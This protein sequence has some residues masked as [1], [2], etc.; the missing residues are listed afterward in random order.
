MAVGTKKCY[1]SNTPQS[2]CYFISTLDVAMDHLDGLEQRFK[3]GIDQLALKAITSSNTNENDTKNE[4][5][6]PPIELLD[7]PPLAEVCNAILSSLNEIRLCSIIALAPKLIQRI[8][9]ILISCSQIL[10]DREARF[11]KSSIETEKAT[12]QQLVTMFAQKLLPY[13]DKCLK[14]MFPIQQQ[15]L[16]T[17]DAKFSLNFEVIHGAMPMKDIVLIKPRPFVEIPQEISEES[18]P[19]VVDRV[20]VISQEIESTEKISVEE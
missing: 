9:M 18:V 5:L 7:F 15:T 11:G 12:F 3:Q 13:L 8:E 17:S 14:T 16:I 2:L 4:D 10:K 20:S 1:Y 19:Y 6:Q